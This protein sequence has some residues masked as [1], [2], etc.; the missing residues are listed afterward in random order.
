MDSSHGSDSS[1]NALGTL[2]TAGM[3][4][5]IRLEREGR[6]Q[7]YYK[8]CVEGRYYF[9][10]A[11]RPAYAKKEYYREMMRKEYELGSQLHSDYVVYDLSGRR[12]SGEKAKN[13]IYIINGK[14][15]LVK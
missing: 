12:V 6:T 11:L 9:M 8:V 13:G 5:Q 2:G 14:K 10:K 4:E 1:L 7:I 3:S 15:I